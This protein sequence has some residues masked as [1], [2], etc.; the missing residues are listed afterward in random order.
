[1]TIRG[2]GK[3]FERAAL[4][5]LILTIILSF[6]FKKFFSFLPETNFFL[7]ITGFF[8]L[9]AGVVLLFLSMVQMAKAYN[10]QRLETKGM[11][12]ICRNPMYSSIIF[13]IIPGLSLILNSWFVLTTSIISYILVIVFIDEENQYLSRK[14]G[15]EYLK[16]KR[17]TGLLLP[18]LP[19]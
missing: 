12:S 15:E 9:T 2:I 7:V 16:Y 6:I 3:I 4:P 10:E 19:K 5:Y 13:L 17:K 8:S 11:Y 18:K 1:M 14:F